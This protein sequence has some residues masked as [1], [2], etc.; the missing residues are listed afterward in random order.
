M[1]VLDISYGDDNHER[2]N[3]RRYQIET[4]TLEEFITIVIKKKKVEMVS[5]RVIKANNL[6]TPILPF[7]AKEETEENDMSTL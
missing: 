2:R 1:L 4:G 7:L 5:T 3:A 6:S